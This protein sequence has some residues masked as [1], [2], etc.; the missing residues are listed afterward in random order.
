MAC[1]VFW[2]FLIIAMWQLK[3]FSEF[4]KRVKEATAE[5]FTFTVVFWSTSAGEIMMISKELNGTIEQMAGGNEPHS[6]SHRQWNEKM[7]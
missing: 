6:K 1:L 2:Q 4:R 5:N 7:T 3:R